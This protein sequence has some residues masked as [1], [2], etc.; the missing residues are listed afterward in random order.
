M[1]TYLKYNLE[2][3][4]CSQAEQQ[5]VLL[6]IVIAQKT[7][8]KMKAAKESDFNSKKSSSFVLNQTTETFHSSFYLP[9]EISSG[10]R[11]LKLGGLKGSETFY[12]I[13][14]FKLCA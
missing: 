3:K 11:L 12:Y 14:K 4:E 2:S 5:K 13:Q 7:S 10:S 6:R 9:C 8:T 1:E